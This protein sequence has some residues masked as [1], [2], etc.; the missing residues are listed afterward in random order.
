MHKK[1]LYSATNGIFEKLNL[2]AERRG[3]VWMSL[4]LVMEDGLGLLC[5]GFYGSREEHSEALP[6]S[7]QIYTPWSVLVEFPEF[8]QQIIGTHSVHL[9]S[10]ISNE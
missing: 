9:S 6:N 7:F 10:H 5:S 4:A 2:L 8:D 1:L 3:K